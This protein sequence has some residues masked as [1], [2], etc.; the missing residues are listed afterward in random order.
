MK[1]KIVNALQLVTF[2]AGIRINF[3]NCCCRN[4]RPRSPTNHIFHTM[5]VEKQR[6]AFMDW[7]DSTALHDSD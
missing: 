3:M 1:T 5:H 7:Q 6:L 4:T 2:I